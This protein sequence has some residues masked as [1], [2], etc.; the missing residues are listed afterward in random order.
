M[1]KVARVN[2]EINRGIAG[3]M[4]KQAQELINKYGGNYTWEQ[5]RH[6]KI[7]YQLSKIQY[8]YPGGVKDST[9]TELEELAKDGNA[10]AKKAIKLLLQTQRL[11]NKS[12]QN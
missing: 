12:G 4:G 6:T 10:E 9:F 3:I 11:N 2:R 8:E 7:D 5:L 1:E